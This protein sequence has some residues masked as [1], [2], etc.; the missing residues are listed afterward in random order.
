MG[1]G[2]DG[3][4]E[5]FMGMDGN[6]SYML[7]QHTFSLSVHFQTIILIAC[8]IAKSAS[9]ISQYSRRSDNIFPRL[10]SSKLSNFCSLKLRLEEKRAHCWSGVIRMNIRHLVACMLAS[11][12]LSSQV[13]HRHPLTRAQQLLRWA[14]VPE[15]GRKVGVLCV[16][17]AGSPSNTMSPGPRPTFIPSGILL[18]RTVWP[19]YTIVTDMAGQTN[20]GPIG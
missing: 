5:E 6:S 15:V 2:W 12:G 8:F 16:G 10:M 20:N 4:G 11:S 1:I 14:T 19:Q 3:N 13:H 9:S 18:Y 7:F 17:G